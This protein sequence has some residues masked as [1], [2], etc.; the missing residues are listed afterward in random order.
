M[1]H[2]DVV[3]FI[4]HYFFGV[5]LCGGEGYYHLDKMSSIFTVPKVL[6]PLAYVTLADFD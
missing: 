1:V 3:L 6:L 2:V 4:H 5:C